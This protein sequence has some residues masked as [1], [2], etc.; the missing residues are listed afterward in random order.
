MSTQEVARR[1]VSLCRT[2]QYE[3]AQK[4]LYSPDAVSIEP[5]GTPAE[6]TKGLDGILAK[7]KAWG[8]MVE[9]VHSA[10]VSEPIVAGNHFSCSM[11]NDVTFK[12]MGRQTIDEVCVYE[13]R[14]GKI[15]KEQ[16][17][18]PVMPQG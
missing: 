7:G 11:T 12:E 10:E 16:F 5:A 8:E 14:D 9:A 3:A 1:L 17:F 2:G 6:V 18:Y 15:V 4:E 13:V